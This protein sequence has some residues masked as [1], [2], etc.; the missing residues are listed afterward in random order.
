MGSLRWL[1]WEWT[2]VGR[3]GPTL[4]PPPISR[5]HAH[6]LARGSPAPSQL[7][8]PHLRR[9]IGEPRPLE[10]SRTHL[11]GATRLRSQTYRSPRGRL[12]VGLGPGS[13][14][15][16]ML[17]TGAGDRLTRVTPGTRR[18]GC[19]G[20]VQRRPGQSPPRGRGMVPR[21]SATGARPGASLQAPMN[22][23][24]RDLD[25]LHDKL[26]LEPK[27]SVAKPAKRRSLRASRVSANKRD[28]PRPPQLR[29][30]LDLPRSP[31]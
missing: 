2:Y 31:Q 11:P 10:W 7:F 24:Q 29:A 18:P 6:N 27:H 16:S 17:G 19:M 5:P 1:S 4:S 23:R 21:H 12:R 13:R 25:L 3:D 9:E 26:L 14:R 22:A 28:S 20:D 15:C 30:E 8:S